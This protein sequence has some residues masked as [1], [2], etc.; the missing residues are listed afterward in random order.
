MMSEPKFG[1]RNSALDTVPNI[2][3]VSNM[4]SSRRL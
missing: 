1:K 2:L 4:V 3:M